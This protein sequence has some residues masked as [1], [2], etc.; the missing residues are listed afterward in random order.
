MG[1]T[2]WSIALVKK[3]R[4]TDIGCARQHHQDKA[5]GH[6]R[7]CVDEEILTLSNITNIEDRKIRNRHGGED[8][9]H[10]S[11]NDVG[12]MR[13]NDSVKFFTNCSPTSINY[14]E[15]RRGVHAPNLMLI[16]EIINMASTRRMNE[17]AEAW[18]RELQPYLKDKF[19][20]SALKRPPTELWRK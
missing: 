8:Q 13:L 20:Y 7:R 16:H 9:Q 3:H 1:R 10:M 15:G 18:L 4:M 5:M 2:S 17:M 19:S 14:R 12:G 6:Q 11:D